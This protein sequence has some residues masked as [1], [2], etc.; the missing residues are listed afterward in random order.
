VGEAQLAG[1][2]KL[3]PETTGGG[4]RVTLI[5]RGADAQVPVLTTTLY[6]PLAAVVTFEIVGFCNV[7]EK[8]LGPV[9]E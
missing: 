6:V 2:E 9:Q 5:V 3:L 7:L 8:L 4:V 1:L